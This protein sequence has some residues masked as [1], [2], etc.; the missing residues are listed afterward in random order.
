MTWLMAQIT[1]EQIVRGE[2]FKIQA[3]FEKLFKAANAPKEAAMFGSKDGHSKIQFYFSPSCSTIAKPLL[4]A[5]S[6]IPCQKPNKDQIVLL[7]GHANSWSN[8]WPD[9]PE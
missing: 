6:A 8:F 7:V 1:N 5:Y 9:E 3:M 4:R 2:G